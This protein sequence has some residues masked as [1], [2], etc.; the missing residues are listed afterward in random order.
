MSTSTWRPGALLSGTAIPA[1]G[2]LV[3]APALA[4]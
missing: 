1:T 4:R 2:S 3:G